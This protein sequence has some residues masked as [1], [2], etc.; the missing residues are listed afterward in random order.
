MPSS[1]SISPVPLYVT[2]FFALAL[3]IA[4]C[5]ATAPDDSTSTTASGG[6]N[7]T[8][9]GGGSASSGDNFTGGHG[10]G[11]AC[12]NDSECPD[13]VCLEG[14]CCPSELACAG[15]CCSTG[16]VCLFDK[17]LTPGND[18][19]VQADCPD[20][21]YCEPALGTETPPVGDCTQPLITGKCLPLPP[22]CTDEPNNPDCIEDCEYHPPIGQ[23]NSKRKWQ[24]GYAPMPSE[25][26]TKAD[27]WSTPV[28]GRM[29]DANC[30]GKV[31]LADPP[32]V[33]FVSA[34]A[35]GTYCHSANNGY[36]CSKGVLRLL[37]G[38]SGEEIWSLEKAAPTSMG[39]AG[40]SV[41]I[42][43][44]DHDKLMDIV[45][46]TGEGKVAIIDRNGNV[47]QLSN[48][49]VD[50]HNTTNFGWGG[51]IALGDMDND[52]WTEIAFGRTVFTMAGGTLKLLFKGA[53]GSGGTI[54]K[55]T[56]HFADLD[57]DGDLELI[58]GRT[59]YQSDGSYLWHNTAVTDGLTA[60]GD[61]DKDGLPE[62][63]VIG[64]GKLSILDGAT[65]NIEIGPFSIPGTGLGGPPTVADFNGDGEPEIGVAMANFYSVLKPDYP[66]TTMT[67]L[68]ST[69]NHDNSSS[70][71]GSS[72][73]DFEG[74]GA[75]EVV[76]MDECFLWVYD[77]TTGNI[78]YGA[79]SQSFTATEAPVVA[80]V[81][82]D[83]H[84]EILMVHNGADPNNSLWHCAHHTGGDG[85]PTWYQ[86][87]SGAYR[88][89][90]LLG[91]VANSWVGTR[92]LWNQH[93]YSVSNICDPRDTAC[94]G[95]T[96]YGQIP[97][98][99]NKNW[100]TSWL[101]NFRQNIQELGLFDAPDPLVKLHVNCDKPVSMKAYVRNLGR[102]TLP[103]NVE[104]GI[105]K[106]PN[107]QIGSVYTSKT[108]LP[109][110]TEAIP[111]VSAM[112]DANTDD[113]FYAEIL[114]DPNQPNFHECRPENNRSDDVN[115][116]CPK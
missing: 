111:F 5:P 22:S 15:V 82:G 71:T 21:E 34:D 76:Y 95:N 58:A 84:A 18:C 65:G 41:A 53:Y 42:G 68:W 107:T 19:V 32:N 64:A 33:I 80:D 74:D 52:G 7:S 13:G 63:V 36:A 77:G 70:V 2:V 59:A 115:P 54:N 89:V 78:L 11:S 48:D 66:N 8:Q 102:A 79:G 28:V 97:Q 49:I 91:D 85:Y 93:A 45:A 81:D 17:C 83:G 113:T 44:V 114:V 9:G 72:V 67:T 116:D 100:N 101:N 112:A 69:Q 109:G 94:T 92:T 103:S 16:D 86:P 47:S 108:L 62:V 25:F 3:A 24:W 40:L 99:Q 104:V 46:L 23:L 14:T 37:D 60:T 30:D 29:F 51:G 98:H 75:A 57:N 38:Q 4:G 96:Y 31:D 106:K 20:G 39:F 1:S 50:G 27:V 6:S 26:P 10:G 61:F 43:D 88:G 56:V 87:N 12:F 35:K 73:F 55:T 90:T 110:Q 105:F